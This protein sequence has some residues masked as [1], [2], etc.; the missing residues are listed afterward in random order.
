MTKTDTNYTNYHEGSERLGQ[1]VQIREIRVSIS[2][3]S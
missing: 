1:L 3:S 2:V